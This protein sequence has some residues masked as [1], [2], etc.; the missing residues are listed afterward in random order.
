MTEL[1]IALK[2]RENFF[3]G[4]ITETWYPTDDISIVVCRDNLERNGQCFVYCAFLNE[5]RL[6]KHFYSLEEAIVYAIA[7]KHDGLNTQAAEYF[8]KMITPL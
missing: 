2:D 5:R 1:R 6:P 8:F 4:R 3:L 7:V